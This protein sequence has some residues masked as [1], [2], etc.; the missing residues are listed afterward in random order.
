MG[1]I[2]MGKRFSVATYSCVIAGVCVALAGTVALFC[3]FSVSENGQGGGS[4]IKFPPSME[5]ESDLGE[6][7]S[8]EIPAGVELGADYETDTHINDLSYISYRVKSGDIIGKIAQKYDVSSDSIIS[9]NSIKSSR[10]LQ[11]GTYLKIPTMSGI[12]YTAKDGDSVPS[13]AQK[14]NVDAEKVAFV[15][16]KSADSQ[17]T[18]GETL[19]VPGAKLDVETLQEINGD[20]FKKPIHASWYRSSNFG[21][22][23]NPFTAARTYHNGIDMACP[24]G[25]S[26]YAAMAG[27]VTATGFSPIYGNYVIITHHSGYKT[28]Y[29]HMSKIIAVKNQS[30]DAGTI[31]GRVGSTGMSTGPHLHFTVYKNNVAV[32]PSI[33]WR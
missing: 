31:I 15:N 8:A 14:F 23:S 32:N 6:I 25:T 30:V 2:K 21:W 16:N 12:L 33:L 1:K 3:G 24:H 28:L 4:D 5:M 22:R 7:S 27:K 20:L 9:L 11:I 13:V 19:F 26:I 29:G 18:S 10:N 17:F